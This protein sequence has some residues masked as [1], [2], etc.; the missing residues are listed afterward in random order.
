MTTDL[1]HLLVRVR[2]ASNEPDAFSFLPGIA[3]TLEA[4]I[5]ANEATPHARALLARGLGRLT[6]EQ[7]SFAASELGHALLQAAD[8]YSE[9]AR[10]ADER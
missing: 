8:S 9:A 2:V 5:T 10:N 4:M 3:R 1:R 6:L 7:C